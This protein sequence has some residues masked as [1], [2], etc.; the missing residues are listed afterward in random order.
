MPAEHDISTMSLDEIDVAVKGYDPYE[1][2]DVPSFHRTNLPPPLVISDEEMGVPRETPDEI[3]NDEMFAQPQTTK[4][5]KAMHFA[6]KVG[7]VADNV[8]WK[9]LGIASWPFER[10]EIGIG[11]PATAVMKTAGPLLRAVAQLAVE[12]FEKEYFRNTIRN[13]LTPYAKSVL[14]GDEKVEEM[15]TNLTDKVVGGEMTTKEVESLLT[16]S[17]SSLPDLIPAFARGAKSFVPFTRNDPEKVKN[18]NDFWAAYYEEI[19]GEQSPELYNQIAGVST[20]FLT[21]PF[22]FGKMLQGL[23]VGAMK[24]PF[25]KNLANRK[26]PDWEEAKLIRKANIYERNEQAA[27]LGKTLAGKDVKRM[28]AQ[29]SL[30]SGRTITPEAVKLRLGQIIKGSITEQEVL[31]KTANPVIEELQ[32]NFKTL[33]KLGILGEETYLTKLTGGRVKELTREKEALLKSLDKLR[34]GVPYKESLATLVK[35]LKI[36]GQQE[37]AKDLKTLTVALSPS[38]FRRR[39]VEFGYKPTEGDKGIARQAQKIA[40]ALDKI[41]DIKTTQPKTLERLVEQLQS[42]EEAVRS[43]T[44]DT[45]LPWALGRLEITQ[46]ITG[47]TPLLKKIMS[48]QRRFPGKTEMISELEGKIAKIEDT[49][50]QSKLHGG[51]GYMPRMY[52]TKEAEVAARK[53]PVSGSPKVRAPYAKAREDIPMAIRKEMGE[54]LEPTYPV[55]KRLIQEGQDI[56]TSKLYN[57]AA[58]HGEWIDTVWREGLAPKALP[59]TKAYGALRGKFVVPQIYNDVTELNRIRSD[60][61]SLYDSIIGTWKMG[62]ITLNPATHSRNVITNTILLDLSGTDHVAQG[63]LFVQALSKI[64]ADSEEYKIAQKYFARTTM[65]S[66]EL[67]DDMLRTVTKEK[68][69]GL[70]RTINTWNMVF[71]KATGAPTQVYQQ[72]EFIFKFMKYLEQREQGK[73]VIGAVQETNKWMFDYGDLAN[74]ERTVARRV[75]P[76]YTFPRKALPRVLEAA[77]DRPLTLAKYPLAAWSMEKYSLHQL[78]LTDTDYEHIKK[79]LP[80]YMQSGSYLLMPWRDNNGDL[81]FFDWSYILPWG[82]LFDAQDRGLLG[83]TVTNPFIVTGSE[84]ML[85]KSG[86]S[87]RE[88]Y[89]D[90]DTTKEKTFKQMI[91]LWQTAVPSLMYKGIYWDKLYN[92]ATGKPSK[93]GKIQ[94]LAP[95]IAHTIFGLRAQ[96]V[97][98]AKEEQFRLIEKRKKVE[99]LEGKIRDIVIREANGNIDEKEYTQKR[100]QYLKQIQGLLTED[101]E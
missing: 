53:F 96:P 45:I 35:E 43:K 20:S 4:L 42:G 11:T 87:G 24:I 70:Q 85:N 48:M 63:K 17:K 79:V 99:E 59:D 15:I 88:I 89:Q 13:G 31:T 54:I 101:T 6:G 80:D 3:S 14:G 71:E 7:K 83:A 34:T 56:E 82:E 73:S 38:K 61:E 1:P 29:L 84:L 51:E 55:T 62:K 66:G 77:A 86:W 50:W 75:M 39:V 32:A 25:I 95:A 21:T 93:M 57:T 78:Q 23:R 72:E 41:L 33:Q 69:S 18:F 9:T 52:A 27:N 44:I 92:V 37:L 90:T 49:I 100:D 30:Q 97:D 16:E 68:A 40:V 64:R 10:I 81:Q 46:K 2:A 98:I 60:F 65:M 47:K 28:A 36:S 5:E 8:F 22:I 19:T 76:F 26:L 58:Q 12:P 67:L 94:P 91:H 74:W